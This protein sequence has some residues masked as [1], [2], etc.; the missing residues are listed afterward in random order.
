LLECDFRFGSEREVLRHTRHTTAFRIIR[1]V[2]GKIK[3]IG[4]GN[5]TRFGGERQTYR[6][7]AIILLAQLSAILARHNY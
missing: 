5:A 2:L 6:Y 4:N 1:S 7:L 3:L